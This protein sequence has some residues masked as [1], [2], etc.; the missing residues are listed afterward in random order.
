MLKGGDNVL[1]IGAGSGYAAALFSEI[2][3]KVYTVERVGKLA[4]QAAELLP[5]SVTTMFMCCT[6]MAPKAG[7]NTHP[8]MPSLLRPAARRCRNP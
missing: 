7:R 5:N 2:A 6:A 8:T 1:E 4:A 3:A